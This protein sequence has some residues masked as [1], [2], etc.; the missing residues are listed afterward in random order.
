MVCD[1]LG[2]EA[3]AASSRRGALA[4]AAAFPAAIAPAAVSADGWT[5]IRVTVRNRLYRGRYR[6]E[7][8]QGRGEQRPWV[9]V[10]S[11]ALLCELVAAGLA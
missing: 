6:V 2:P 9:E 8:G 11:E 3:S 5:R 1:G 10:V 7:G 4:D